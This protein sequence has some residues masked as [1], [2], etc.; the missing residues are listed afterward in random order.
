MDTANN[1]P[2][3][4]RKK[5]RGEKQKKAKGGSGVECSAEDMSS[6]EHVLDLG[7]N[8]PE[9]ETSHGVV[10]GL[11]GVGEG[12]ESQSREGAE[13]VM[14]ELQASDDTEQNKPGK[15]RDAPVELELENAISLPH[16][17][18]GLA[19][20]KELPSAEGGWI[21]IGTVQD[22][23]PK[24]EEAIGNLSVTDLAN[25]AENRPS[26]SNA[27]HK[28][29]REM[30]SPKGNFE[31]ASRAHDSEDTSSKLP[32]GTLQDLGVNTKERIFARD[33]LASETQVVGYLDLDTQ[34]NL[35]EELQGARQDSVDKPPTLFSV[36]NLQTSLVKS[37]LCF[38][39]GK[40]RN[41]SVDESFVDALDQLAESRSTSLEESTFVTE[42]G[43]QDKEQFLRDLHAC[44]DALV[45]ANE[46]KMQL[47]SKLNSYQMQ[48]EKLA[49]EKLSLSVK[50]QDATSSEV[51]EHKALIEQEPLKEVYHGWEQEKS[52]MANALEELRT[53]L[54]AE[55]EQRGCLL[56]EMEITQQKLH[57]FSEE[58]D[59]LASNLGEKVTVIEDMK[60]QRGFLEEKLEIAQFEREKLAKSVNQSALNFST[61]QWKV[62][63]LEAE[64]ATALSKTLLEVESINETQEGQH[65]LEAEV[66][67]FAE[68]GKVSEKN[69]QRMEMLESS[70]QILSDEN[71][72]N[73]LIKLDEYSEN[74]KKEAYENQLVRN[75]LAELKLILDEANTGKEQIRRDYES[76]KL[77]TGSAIV[78]KERNEAEAIRLR[79]QIDELSL[80]ILHLKDELNE[81]KNEKLKLMGD[82]DEY[83]LL[84]EKLECERAD[85]SKGFHLVK[86]ELEQM[87]REVEFQKTL[88]EG[89]NQLAEENN[90]LSVELH[91]CKKWL[92]RMQ[93]EQ[94]K[95]NNHLKDVVLQL[96][97]AMHESMYLTSNLQK[98]THLL[99]EAEGEFSK[100]TRK[101][102]ADSSLLQ[103]QSDLLHGEC[104]DQGSSL[105]ADPNDCEFAMHHT[106]ENFEESIQ[107]STSESDIMNI[108]SELTSAVSATLEIFAEYRIMQDERV[109]AVREL[110]S[111]Y[112]HLRKMVQQQ[113]RM[114][115]DGKELLTRLRQA[116]VKESGGNMQDP[117]ALNI[118]VDDCGKFVKQ[119][120]EALGERSQYEAIIRELESALFTKDKD[121]QDI[122]GRYV[123]LSQKCGQIEE[124]SAKCILLDEKCADMAKQ[125]AQLTNER[126]SLHLEV[127]ALQLSLQD[128]EMVM[129]ASADSH[130]DLKCQFDMATEKLIASIEEAIQDETLFADPCMQRISYLETSLH[131]LIEKYKASISQVNLFQKSLFELASSYVHLWEKEAT[132][133]LDGILRELFSCKEKEL[134]ESYEK[135]DEMKSIRA[136]QEAEVRE[137]R[138][139]LFKTEE[140]LKELK[141]ESSKLRNDL[142]QTE[143][144]LS[145]VREKLSMAVSKGKGLVQQ[146]D[147]L[148]QSLIDKSNELDKCL[149]E[150]Q[151]KNNELH[152]AEMKDSEHVKALELELSDVQSSANALQESLSHKDSVLQ[153]IQNILGEVN[154]PYELCSKE[155]VDKIEWLV[156][157]SSGEENASH[158]SSRDWK[159]SEGNDTHVVDYKSPGASVDCGMIDKRSV[160]DLNTMFEE[161]QDK[162]RSLVEQAC[163]TEQALSERNHLIQR[164]EKALNSI[165]I[166][167]S[168]QSFE[169]ESKI[170]WICK[171]L[172]Q[173]QQDVAHFQYEIE[174]V[175]R[176]ADLSTIELE[177]SKRRINSLEESLLNEKREKEVFVKDLEELS[178]KYE[179]LILEAS[180]ET[181]QKGISCGELVDQQ[182]EVHDRES[183]L[184]SN[185]VDKCS[186]AE[187]CI[188][189][190]ADIV[191][192]TMKDQD[193]E[194]LSSYGNNE[195]HL[196][197][198]IRKLIDKLN[199]LSKE[200]K[201][202]KETDNVKTEELQS[203]Q[204]VVDEK[205]M[206]LMVF[207][208]KQEE[209]YSTVASHRA[210]I[211]SLM[212]QNR[213]M[214]EELVTIKDQ[215]NAL[216]A[217]LEEAEERSVVIREKL[218]MA[219]KKGK[220]LVQ[221]RDSLKQSVDEKL[222]ELEHLRV[223]LQMKFHLG[224][225][226]GKIEWL[227]KSVCQLQEKI[228]FAEEET[229]K[230]KVEADIFAIKLDEACENVQTLE[231]E[232]RDSENK[233][234]M[235]TNKIKATEAENNREIQ[236]L[237]DV[238][239]ARTEELSEAHIRVD[240]QISELSKQH[241]SLRILKK[242]YGCLLSL[243]A[244]DL[245]K[246]LD[247]LRNM[248]LSFQDL[249]SQLDKLEGSKCP[250]LKLS[251]EQISTIME[252]EFLTNEAFI[253]TYTEEHVDR[254]L[255]DNDLH[256]GQ[257]VD[258]L[259]NYLGCALDGCTGQLEFLKDRFGLYSNAVD[260]GTRV[261]SQLLQCAKGDV[262]IL[263]ETFEP[264]KQNV[265]NLEALNKD[266][267]AKIL[268]L[269]DSIITLV[270]GCK[271]A[272][273]ELQNVKLQIISDSLS[274]S[275]EV[276]TLGC[277]F[278]AS[279]I[280]HAM[281]STGK[282]DFIS[283]AE[284]K[285]TA[286]SLLFTITDV[287][288]AANEKSQHNQREVD[289]LKS[290]FQKAEKEAEQLKAFKELESKLMKVEAVAN[291]I[292]R[293]RD[294]DKARICELESYIA[295]LENDC[296][297]LELSVK[298]FQIREASMKAMQEEFA[299]L[300]DALSTKNKELEN[301]YKEVQA[302]ENDCQQKQ[303]TLDSLESSWGKSLSELSD[304]RCRF[305]ELRQLSEGLIAEV[306][307]L[308]LQLESRDE[309]I[310]QLKE[311][312]TKSTY[313]IPALLENIK[314][315][316]R[317]LGDLQNGLENIITKLGLDHILLEQK[318]ESRMQAVLGTLEKEISGI[319]SESENSKA[320]V[321]DKDALLHNTQNSIEELTSKVEMLE[322]SLREKETQF[323][324]FRLEKHPPLGASAAEVSEI[325][326]V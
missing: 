227:G 7:E 307:N 304:M 4:K 161:L 166:P 189:R 162:Y 292:A 249:L 83:K 77:E 217:Q 180:Q 316:N 138:D 35:I 192:E 250:S 80:H 97:N 103:N 146:R 294:I 125:T 237:K 312:A 274:S 257:I 260:Q 277:T 96:R 290:K 113:E 43:L 79:H 258:Q 308:H 209:A 293:E 309:E 32:E 187:D 251:S 67:R 41:M 126:D 298:D 12:L 283:A 13:V 49:E 240:C 220:G 47:V 201:M 236:A 211:E 256:R 239:A 119:L 45:Q 275:E 179:Q 170:E 111:T 74:T 139:T 263:M 215:K 158:S 185:A 269:H 231:D 66:L 147:T 278:S 121:I 142:D 20:N 17:S 82:L 28:Q 25:D 297:A 31:L 299:S 145:S 205:N 212:E 101:A 200:V 42:S 264:L 253:E 94:L 1:K 218:T 128:K 30:F 136:Q 291:D 206:T 302:L 90:K 248:E 23:G 46:E 234:S 232:L 75:E 143:T 3:G 255:H 190:L 186:A 238:L 108:D 151:M 225:T 195:E 159:I 268:M 6:G 21:D 60:S 261:L 196:E 222:S 303:A 65:C 10:L 144:K 242:E 70:L 92:S 50:L 204:A 63:D 282:D 155:I 171:A 72:K 14:M 81:V 188:R 301:L 24:Q 69:V 48:V 286:Q 184:E 106:V 296:H 68:E 284:C 130:Y 122:N 310:T 105:G 62:G 315:K 73:L 34:Q 326:E 2:G 183:P 40:N 271:T 306:E 172:S 107:Q 133:P 320:A 56:H 93:D 226:I 134:T 305:E 127:E 156:R 129:K 197:G 33:E 167:T 289:T 243:L 117:M 160:D 91:D 86:V 203:L 85:L 191:S 221:Q 281:Q 95:H 279:E 59:V 178:C 52:E 181:I 88:E 57:E 149:Q 223:E 22:L 99:V 29:T 16:C 202:L 37:L 210:E 140:T 214:S 150:L 168:T 319:M 19:D 245:P 11:P 44:K 300:H 98:H 266:K 100:S 64:K 163:M 235:L 132:V 244:N 280:S 84:G 53:Q 157:S 324:I 229:K 246:K 51:P 109:S 207:N 176:V 55:A 165:D 38:K 54:Q 267:D 273:E 78:E 9:P 213:I 199:T 193:F 137:L 272:M 247:L 325:E 233:I 322:A 120:Q 285:K 58:R 153:K 198:C 154:L 152:A 118:L 115:E 61:L 219:V 18:S 321:Q 259:V 177:E 318:G 173:A 241:A 87:R 311:E 287:A 175:Q 39:D 89:R 148:K 295:S 194:E 141:I 102:H 182:V 112:D 254:L 76:Y 5:K 110:S 174:S 276:T 131:L 230:C 288:N 262:V 71:H 114:S 323:E 26:S 270:N 116:E 314:T 123:E 228:S 313:D 224:D 15:D 104:I 216:K 164:W 27:L 8:N 135:L 317:E 208:K 124:V 252:G 36:G 265:A 169:P